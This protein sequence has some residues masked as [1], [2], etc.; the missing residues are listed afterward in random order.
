MKK[1]NTKKTPK[2]YAKIIHTNKKL[3]QT[4]KKQTKTQKEW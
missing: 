4:K 1:I 2:T 3:Q